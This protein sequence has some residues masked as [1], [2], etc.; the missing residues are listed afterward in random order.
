[1]GAWWEGNA[2][3]DLLTAAN[4]RGFTTT[5]AYDVA[6]NATSVTDVRGHTSTTAYD[7]LLDY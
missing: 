6:G 5:F 3:S 2:D 4:P 1:L 7:A